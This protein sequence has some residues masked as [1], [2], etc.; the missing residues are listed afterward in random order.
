LAEELTLLSHGARLVLEGAAVVGHPFEPELAAAAAATTEGSALK[1]ID[2]LLKLDLV[3]QTDVP[4]R[5]RFRHPLIR[6]AVYLGW[7]A[8]GRA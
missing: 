5:F 2:E 1:A 8:T 3:R 4:R 6:R 7:L